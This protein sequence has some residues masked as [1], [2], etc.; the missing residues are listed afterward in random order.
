MIASALCEQLDQC[1][2]LELADQEHPE[3][4]LECIKKSGWL[5][6]DCNNKLGEGLLNFYIYRS[7]SA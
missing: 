3:Y 2:W 5:I 4:T 6:V 1:P 7:R